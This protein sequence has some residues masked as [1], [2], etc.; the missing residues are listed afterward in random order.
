MLKDIYSQA[1]L[2][3]ECY[4]SHDRL[5]RY[6]LVNLSNKKSACLEEFSNIRDT[7]KKPEA[8]VSKNSIESLIKEKHFIEDQLIRYKMNIEQIRSFKETCMDQLKDACTKVRIKD[9]EI[10]NLRAELK[11]RE[12]GSRGPSKYLS[13]LLGDRL[14]FKKSEFFTKP[15]A[16]VS[17]KSSTMESS[18]SS[19]RFF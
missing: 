7:V 9:G 15:A 2:H 16:A 14:G 18:K 19:L 1:Q 17:G 11:R 12:E 8:K 5:L 3:L 13:G 6:D 4:K 10:N